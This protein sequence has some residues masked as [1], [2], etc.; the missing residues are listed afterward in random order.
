MHDFLCEYSKSRGVV[1]PKYVSFKD[2]LTISNRT[3]F[4]YRRG[5]F[6]SLCA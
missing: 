4:T 2:V 3:S 1:P 5:F 6:E